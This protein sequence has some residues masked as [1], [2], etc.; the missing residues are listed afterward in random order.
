MIKQEYHTQ[1]DKEITIILSK[2]INEVFYKSPRFRHSDNKSL[3]KILD[4]FQRFFRKRYGINFV[5]QDTMYKACC[6]CGVKRSRDLNNKRDV[7]F[8]AQDL[9]IDI[10]S[11]DLKL[12]YIASVNGL[13]GIGDSKMNKVS[14]FMDRV[15]E[16]EKKNKDLFK[17]YFEMDVTLEKFT[18]V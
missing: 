1:F 14:D 15:I 16:F 2:M 17:K 7:L 8:G 13:C 9:Y 11:S 3:P 10:N 18:T 12:M 5:R 6:L 4:T